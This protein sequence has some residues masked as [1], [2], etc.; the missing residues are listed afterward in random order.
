MDTTYIA[1]FWFSSSGGSLSRL[2]SHLFKG[3]FEPVE[4]SHSEVGT[5]DTSSHL[6]LVAQG[7]WGSPL[8]RI[9]ALGPPI[10]DPSS[11]STSDSMKQEY[12][13]LRGGLRC[14]MLATQVSLDIWVEWPFCKTLWVLGENWSRGCW[15]LKLG[16]SPA[17]RSWGSR[18]HR[19]QGSP[20]CGVTQP[21]PPSHPSSLPP[22]PPVLAPLPSS[23]ASQQRENLRE[24][25]FI[26]VT[27]MSL[28]GVERLKDEASG[29]SQKRSES[30]SRS[31][32]S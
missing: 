5:S 20:A 24:L 19:S 13:S 12:G 14:D 18:V 22:K 32:S 31:S 15:A 16:R 2:L 25:M 30:S 10:W 3:E 8:A 7:L 23:R 26:L 9:T 11:H 17:D 6:S 4:D 1:S 29:E 27:P 21:Q 28:S